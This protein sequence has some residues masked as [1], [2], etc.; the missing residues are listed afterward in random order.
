M[1]DCQ[2]KLRH[3]A[4]DIS[5]FQN[6][7][8]IGNQSMSLLNH[9][10]QGRQEQPHGSLRELDMLIEYDGKW[11]DEFREPKKVTFGGPATIPTSSSLSY[12][13]RIWGAPCRRFGTGRGRGSGNM[14]KFGKDYQAQAI[15]N[16]LSPLFKLFWVYFLQNGLFAWTATATSAIRP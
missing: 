4:G 6:E 16:L 7:S 15:F 5:R 8:A 9:R 1:E 12:C 14:A 3:T 11:I 2:N 13:S 10:V